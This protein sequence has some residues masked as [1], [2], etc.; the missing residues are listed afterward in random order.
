MAEMEFWRNRSAGLSA[1]YEQ[2]TMP[3]V[4]E[5]IVASVLSLI[6]VLTTS[7]LP[8]PSLKIEQVLRVLEEAEIQSLPAFQYHLSELSKLYVEAKDNVKFLR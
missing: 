1:L 7:H 2:I 3:K 6:P 8:P 5:Y 4:L